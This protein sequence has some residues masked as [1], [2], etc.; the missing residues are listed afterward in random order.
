MPIAFLTL[1]GT[2]IVQIP[3]VLRKFECLKGTFQFLNGGDHQCPQCASVCQV[4]EISNEEQTKS[5]LLM[6][7]HGIYTFVET[8]KSN[9]RIS[10][11][12]FGPDRD[13]VNRKE[14]Q[15]NDTH[16]FSQCFIYAGGKC[17]AWLF[18]H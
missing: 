11:D 14:C 15:T 13:F 16:V 3:S 6:C 10:A 1:L 4:R 17:G 18:A 8:K 2:F 5:F 9:Q 12:V 7:Y